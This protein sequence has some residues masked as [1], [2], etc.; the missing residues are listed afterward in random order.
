MS[1]GW[2][3]VEIGVGPDEVWNVLVAPGRRKWY[4]LLTPEGSFT[5]GSQIRWVDARGEA[6][7]ESDILEVEAPRRLVL[8]TH[9]LFA[10]P[11]AAA[12]PHDVTWEV[13]G[14]DGGAQVRMSWQGEGPAARLMETEGA[15]LLEGLRLAAD[16][17]ARSALERLPDIGEVEVRD[18]TPDL[19]TEYQHFFDDVAFRDFPAWQSCYCMETHRT[20]S[21]EE[22][23]GRTAPDNA[24]C[25]PPSR[26][27]R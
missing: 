11:F 3:S 17:S 12:P 4:Y 20:Q 15:A 1:S 13:A 7:E 9:F 8:R 24:T 19:V 5:V 27:A 23:A 18:V 14:T 6:A 22:W 2:H 10:P 16:P 26:S 21:D 25:R